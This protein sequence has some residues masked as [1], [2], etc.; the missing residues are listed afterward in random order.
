LKWFAD[1][2]YIVREVDSELRFYSMKFGRSGFGD[3]TV[4]NSFPFYFKLQPQADG[5]LSYGVVRKI[6][7]MD[8]QKEL[9]SLWQ[10]AMGDTSV[11][12]R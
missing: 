1:G 11:Y 10:R 12:G 3:T 4:E 9:G 5:S 7:N 2:L 6:D 8:I